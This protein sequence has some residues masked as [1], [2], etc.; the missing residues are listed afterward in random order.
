MY[1]E[2]D[3]Y[4]YRCLLLFQRLEKYISNEL[5]LK[6]DL[7]YHRNLFHHRRHHLLIVSMKIDRRHSWSFAGVSLLNEPIDHMKYISHRLMVVIVHLFR[8][9]FVLFAVFV[10][11]NA[12]ELVLFRQ[13]VH[14]IAV[15]EQPVQ[16]FADTLVDSNSVDVSSLVFYH[17]DDDCGM[18]IA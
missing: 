14:L 4:H 7:C 10:H 3:H 16:A 2:E 13:L 1:F 9:N 18:M 17:Y 5:I 12:F 8:W 6:V 15:E 11:L